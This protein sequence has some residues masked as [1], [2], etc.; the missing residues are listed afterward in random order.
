MLFAA[1]RHGSYHQVKNFDESMALP[2]DLV[3]GI[4]F[5]EQTNGSAVYLAILRPGV[6]WSSQEDSYITAAKTSLDNFL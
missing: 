1:I 5:I 3:D 6:Y 4:D 2:G